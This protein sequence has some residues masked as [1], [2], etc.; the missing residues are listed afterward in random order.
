MVVTADSDLPTPMALRGGSRTSVVLERGVAELTFEVHADVRV[1]S[2]PIV[3]DDLDRGAIVTVTPTRLR[4][5]DL[6]I[7]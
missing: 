6:P 5:R 3:T 4:V 1:R 2:L 7:G